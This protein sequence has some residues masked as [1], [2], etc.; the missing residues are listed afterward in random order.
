MSNAP[1]VVLTRSA[2]ENQALGARLA[3]S[4]IT[5]ID[6]PM[7]EVVIGN[8]NTSALESAIS[9]L[10]SFQWIVFTS[11]NGVRSFDS[12]YKLEGGTAA[13]HRHLV[14]AVV[15]P[16]TRDAMLKTAFG[17]TLSEPAPLPAGRLAEGAPAVGKLVAVEHAPRLFTAPVATAADLVSNFPTAVPQPTPSGR[18][19]GQPKV[20]AV[21][22]QLADTTVQAGLK[23]KGYAVSRVDAYGNVRPEPVA[24]VPLG[25]V[26][27][28]F[29]PSAVDRFVEFYGPTWPAVCIGPRTAIQAERHGV[30]VVAI[31]EPHTEVGVIAALQSLF[32]SRSS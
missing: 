3:T 32:E 30:E 9:E 7:I 25:S 22:G 11:A 2:D 12:V 17:Q 15:G 18:E 4:G 6:A 21:L 1:A 19:S 24:E 28:F 16:A 26:I 27:A 20:L 13:P 10:D 31:A 23:A 29:S 8:D 14:A 5:T